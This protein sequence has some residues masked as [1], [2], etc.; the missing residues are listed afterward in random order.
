[1]QRCSRHSAVLTELRYFFS[2]R[3]CALRAPV[4]LPLVVRLRLVLFAPISVVWGELHSES[5]EEEQ[6][7]KEKSAMIS[8]GELSIRSGSEPPSGPSQ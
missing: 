8:V 3:L 6:E 2:T 4:L 1:M 5:D 7:P